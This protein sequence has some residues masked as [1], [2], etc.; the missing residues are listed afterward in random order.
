MRALVRRPFPPWVKAA[1]LVVL[2]LMAVSLAR[3]WR[4]FQ[5]YV[6]IQRARRQM[7]AGRPKAAHELMVSAVTHVPE[8][9][10]LS[11]V[12][13]YYEAFAVA[14]D[15]DHE[16]AYELISAVARA[17]AG[18]HFLEGQVREFDALRYLGRARQAARDRQFAKAS[19]LAGEAA[20]RLPDH[21]FIPLERDV[22]RGLD[23]VNNDRSAEALAIFRRIQQAE[24]KFEAIAE[25]IASADLGAAFEAKDYDAFLSKSRAFR[26][27]EPNNVWA[28]GGLASALACKYAVTGESSF[29]AESMRCLE[30][31]RGLGGR[32]PD[33]NEFREYE[34]RIL[35]RIETRQI[36]PKKEYDRLYR[37]PGGGPPRPATAPA[38][39]EREKPT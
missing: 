1:G 38:S 2:A 6:E 39:P 19:D 29:K 14:G 32:L 12:A 4:F 18:D 34:E 9:P 22:Y 35:H 5:G 28:V 15:G 20:S 13:A 33:A 10:E 8:R 3:N 17:N 26:D 25:L 16:R 30:E 27:A 37:A 11:Q 23:L 21:P 36:I 7:E 24:P 31:A